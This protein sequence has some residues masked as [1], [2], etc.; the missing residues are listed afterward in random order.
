VEKDV[1]KIKLNYSKGNGNIGECY[2]C[3]KSIVVNSGFHSNWVCDEYCSASCLR[4]QETGAKMVFF[5]MLLLGIFI[6]TAFYYTQ[7]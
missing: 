2:Y 5:V 6:L 7:K 4:N 3:K 1:E